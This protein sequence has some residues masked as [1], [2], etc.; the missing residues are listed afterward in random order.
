MRKRILLSIVVFVIMIAIGMI[1]TKVEAANISS[2]INGIN[3]GA[4]PGVKDAIKAMQARNPNW[5]FNV[6]YTGL[7]WDEV[8][9]GEYT[10]HGGSPSN[11]V[12]QTYPYSWI[13]S[14]CGPHKP[15]DVSGEWRC[16]SKEAIAYMMDPRNSLTE[17]YVFQFQDLS[18]SVGD[19]NAIKVMTKNTFLNQES[20]IDAIMQAAKT[21]SVS[22]FHIVSR[23]KQEQGA[24]GNG[25]MNGYIYTTESGERVKVYNL[26]NINVSGNGPQG[27]LAGAKT[28][29]ENG[30]TTPEK[31]IIGGTK[32]IKEKYINVGQTTLYFQK[33]NVVNKNA[34]YGHQYMQN[35]MAA[36]NEGMTMYKAYKDNG[37]LNSS[38][39]FTIPLYE[40]MPSQPA[41]R[42]TEEYRGTIN[43]ELINID[44]SYQ[45]NKNYINGYVYIAEWVG[46]DCRTPRGIPQ[47][48]L[49]STDGSVNKTMYVGY[50]EG[51]KYYFDKVIDDIDMNKEYYIEARLTSDKNI[52]QESKKRQTIYIPNQTIKTNYKGRTVK[53]INNKIVFSIG[54]YVGNINTE[55]E[56][57]QLVQN[58]NG[59][60]YLAG[61]VHI[62]EYINQNGSTP[63]SM[64]R[65][66]LKS[67]DGKFATT[68]YVGYEGQCKYYFD[69]IIENLD[70]TKKYYLEAELT[71]EENKGN[72]KKQQIKIANQ[73]VG[74]FKCFTVNVRENKI[75]LNYEANINTELESISLIQSG[76]SHFISGYMYIGEYINNECKTPNMIPKIKL[77]ATDGSFETNMYV[78][79]EGS[80]KYYFDKKIDDLNVN[81]EYYIEAEL[82]NENN[83]SKQKTQQ[84]KIKNQILEKGNQFKIQIQNNKIKIIDKTLYYGNVN[85]ELYQ[86]NII[87]NGK[88]ENY[89]SGHIYIAEWVGNECRTPSAI[90]QMKLKATDGSFETTMYV[91]HERGIEYYFDKNIENLDTSKKYYIEVKLTGNKNIASDK[92]KTQV[93][94]MSKQG[95]VGICTNGNKVRIEGNNIII[96][97]NKYYGNINTELYQMNIIQNGK[98]ENYISGH[99][100]IA[101]WVGNECRTPSAIPQMK[102]KATDGSFE[103]TMY[104][105]HERGIEYYFDKNIENLDTSKKYYIEVKLTGNKNIASDKNKTQVAKMSKQGEVGI[106]TNGNKVRIE[107]NNIIIQKKAI[108]MQTK[109]VEPIE[110]N[111]KTEPEVQENTVTDRQEIEEKTEEPIEETE[112]KIEQIEDK[113]KKEESLAL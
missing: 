34:L 56:K 53:V 8:I 100:Y 110:E 33:F 20:Y 45:N 104:V 69:K 40:K 51:I 23:L 6:L 26:Y 77:K 7:T 105:G 22:P 37:I 35:V 14:I 57:I 86:M 58:G 42:P 84:V 18:S 109:K 70:L 9:K 3:E 68:M 64:P 92:N 80:I 108:R 82:S 1:A 103:T 71:T 67:T 46:D 74:K 30:W 38:F 55:L 32:F 63:K 95:E 89:I 31:S 78:G 36:N 52:E 17:D 62:V 10:G 75:I 72:N 113:Q 88:G 94:K 102:L 90:P 21:H 59:E 65:I 54:Q 28:A 19:R 47:L 83:V 111:K 76:N 101:E 93:A 41:L 66:W 39:E 4:Y 107:G 43:T 60:T 106:C 27:Y 29:Y 12:P 16:A 25:I 96:K 81:K 11:L 98:G 48:T 91:G 85:T 15:Y 24:S 49:K 44:V 50:E 87:Q 97:D 73:E 2:N 112:E 5:K 79:Y 99:I 61:F 13:C